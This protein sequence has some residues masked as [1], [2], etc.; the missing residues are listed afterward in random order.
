LHIEVPKTNFVSTLR[1]YHSFKNEFDE[2][3]FS[4][5]VI[6]L[7][8]RAVTFNVRKDGKRLWERG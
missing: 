8:P 5:K 3:Y 6:S 1:V 4:D 7:I 2:F